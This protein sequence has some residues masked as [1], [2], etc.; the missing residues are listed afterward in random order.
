M[1]ERMSIFLVVLLAAASLGLGACGKKDSQWVEFDSLDCGFSAQMPAEPKTTAKPAPYTA[2]N[3]TFRH[4]PGGS[5]TGVA[6]VILCNKFSTQEAP[7]SDD[8]EGFYGRFGSNLEK[9][10]DSMHYRDEDLDLEW[11]GVPGRAILFVGSSSRFRTRV[12]IRERTV[13]TLIF[14]HPKRKPFSKLREKFFSSLHFDGATGVTF[15]PERAEPKKQDNARARRSRSKDRG[16]ARGR[17]G[18]SR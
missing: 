15:I 5:R 14:E 6:F 10:L 1:R 2:G 16:G 4:T 8:P 11:E 13:V 12:F 17:R 18:S 9:T 3:W 7:I